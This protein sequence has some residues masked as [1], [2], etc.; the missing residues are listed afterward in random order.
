ML[1][2]K[3][4][5]RKWKWRLKLMPIYCKSKNQ[6]EHQKC[7]LM[8]QCGLEQVFLIGAVNVKALRFQAFFQEGTK[9]E[10]KKMFSN[11]KQKNV[12]FLTMEFLL[13]LLCLSM[14]LS[15]SSAI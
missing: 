8:H 14:D 15:F 10:L 4:L 11:P 6:Q 7:S 5:N 1:R 12:N 9:M 3:N 13:S 2:Q